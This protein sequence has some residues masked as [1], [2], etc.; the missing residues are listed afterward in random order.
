MSV[1][2]YTST[3]IAFFFQALIWLHLASSLGK[4]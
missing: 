4:I 3:L 1:V 2:T